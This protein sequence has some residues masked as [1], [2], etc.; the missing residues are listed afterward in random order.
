MEVP[1]VDAPYSIEYGIHS[2]SIAVPQL[3]QCIQT[4]KLAPHQASLKEP[5]RSRAGARCGDVRA[6]GAPVDELRA[7]RVRTAPHQPQSLAR[8]D[9]AATWDLPLSTHDVQPARCAT[10]TPRVV[11]V[12]CRC[13]RRRAICQKRQINL[14]E[15]TTLTR[16]G[17]RRQLESSHQLS[18]RSARL[19]K[20]L[21]LVQSHLELP[22]VR[23]AS[24]RA[25]EHLE[26]PCPSRCRHH[27]FA[28]APYP[29]LQCLCNRVKQHSR[30][31]HA[32]PSE[33]HTCA[34]QIPS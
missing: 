32:W 3:P 28:I 6:R 33:L 14:S 23:W 26:S 20:T 27:P 13:D 5:R 24:E 15:C 22:N 9:L 18:Y 17:G 29:T 4:P 30:I 31:C 19:P 10:G 16:D 25:V 1:T 7:A 34:P 11:V 2:S 8:R 12:F 21:Q